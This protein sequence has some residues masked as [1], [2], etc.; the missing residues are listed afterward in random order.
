MS[1]QQ[2]C[3]FGHRYFV[4]TDGTIEGLDTIKIYVIVVC[5]VCKASHIIEH[6]LAKDA[7][8]LTSKENKNP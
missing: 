8:Q 4:A 7:K 3:E 6:L 1:N 5:T 2:W